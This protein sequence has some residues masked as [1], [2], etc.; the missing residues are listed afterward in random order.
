KM[1]FH[2][3]RKAEKF[4]IAMHATNG[5]LPNLQYE[6]EEPV[7]EIYRHVSRQELFNLLDKQG[8][9]RVN[10][11]FDKVC[12]PALSKAFK[13]DK[14]PELVEKL[15]EENFTLTDF[16]ALMSR[17]HEYGNA[18]EGMRFEMIEAKKSVEKKKPIHWKEVIDDLMYALN[19]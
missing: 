10:T 12:R 1:T 6:Q 7:R 9:L 8:Y 15:A 17:K 14:M 5:W 4:S 19:F 18:F 13:K 16:V 2:P 3:D 11:F